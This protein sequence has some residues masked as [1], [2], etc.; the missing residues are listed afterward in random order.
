MVFYLIPS[1]F[2]KKCWKP[3]FEPSTKNHVVELGVTPQPHMFHL[4][5]SFSSSHT[6]PPP[7][8]SSPTWL[9]TTTNSNP[10]TTNKWWRRSGNFHT[11]SWTIRW[12]SLNA[13]HHL[14]LGRFKSTNDSRNRANWKREGDRGCSSCR[15][16]EKCNMVVAKL[17]IEREI[18]PSKS[19]QSWGRKKMSLSISI[20]DLEIQSWAFSFSIQSSILTKPSRIGCR[21]WRR[22]KMRVSCSHSQGEIFLRIFLLHIWWVCWGL[23]KRRRWWGMG[24]A[25]V[26]LRAKMVGWRAQWLGKKEEK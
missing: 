5:R 9:Q 19:L 17:K 22:E 13:Q 12:A 24:T 25:M 18:H 14:T 7:H 8:F 26:I 10:K 3:R 16:E 15:S 1:N 11:C 4:L 23:I 6:P 21:S 20:W 2:S